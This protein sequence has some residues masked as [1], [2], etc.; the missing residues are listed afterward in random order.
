M[1]DGSADGSLASLAS[2]ACLPIETQSE[3]SLYEDVSV[4]LPDSDETQIIDNEEDQV[5]LFSISNADCLFGFNFSCTWADFVNVRCHHNIVSD[6]FCYFLSREKFHCSLK[7][8]L[9]RFVG[10]KVRL[11]FYPNGG[12]LKP[13]RTASNIT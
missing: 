7:S 12:L 9:E 1:A 8:N 10:Q 5:R 3:D 11:L 6:I 2:L 4:E 13:S